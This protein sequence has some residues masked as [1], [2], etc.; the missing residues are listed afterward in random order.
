ME[1][2][3]RKVGKIIEVD[4][5]ILRFKNFEG[6]GDKYN[7]QGDR[8]FTWVIK[9]PDIAEDMREWGYNVK[10]RTYVDDD[11]N[12]TTEWTLLI[13]VKYRDGRGPK[14]Y[15]KTGKNKTL[16]D[17]ETLDTLDTMYINKFDFDIR[18]YEWTVNGDSG[19]TAYLDS[20]CAFVESD[21]FSDEGYGSE[22]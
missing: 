7:H 22:W 18:P 21:R 4:N 15:M 8:N 5:A 1:T 17:E 2:S 13:K 20:A 16:L 11:G 9:D 19:I 6:R 3:I 10:E 12:K 14:V